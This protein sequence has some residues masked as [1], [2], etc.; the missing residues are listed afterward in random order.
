MTLTLPFAPVMSLEA[1]SE[2]FDWLKRYLWTEI[3]TT[4]L[5]SAQIDA[6]FG[7]TPPGNGIVVSD[8]TNSLVLVRQAGKWAKAS[9]TV[10]P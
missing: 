9:L 3:N 6:L 8:P 7:Q 1:A 2:N 5:S 10:I 4:G